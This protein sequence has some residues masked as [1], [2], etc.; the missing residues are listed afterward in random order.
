MSQ[1]NPLGVVISICYAC[2]SLHV[3]LKFLS[4]IGR[5]F[6]N[7]VE[8]SPSEKLTVPL[9][10]N[11]PNFTEPEGSL[12]HS[13]APAVSPYPEPQQSSPCPLIP[14]PEDPS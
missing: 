1:L 13:Q 12:P 10:R 6:T 2:R 7:Y 3:R 5:Y 8:Q 4:L 9:L 14:L 11:S